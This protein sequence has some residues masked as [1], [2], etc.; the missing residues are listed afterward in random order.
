MKRSFFIQANSKQLLGAKLA[1][2]AIETTGGASKAG[3]P[4]VIL[5]VDQDKTYLS[6][7]GKTYRRGTE[8]RTHDK[9]DLQFF[10]LSRF[11]PPEIMAYEGRSVVI[12]P[13]IFALKEVTSLFDTELNGNS[14]AACKKSDGWDSSVMVLENRALSHWKINDILFSLTSGSSDYNDWSRLKKES[15]VEI[16]REWNSLDLITENTKFLHTTNRLTQPWRTG[17][18]IDFTF[19][20]PPRLF[21]VIPRF[22]VVRPTHYLPHPDQKVVQAFKTLAAQALD[23]GAVTENDIHTAIK[24]RDVRPDFFDFLQTST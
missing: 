16:S 15:V 3:I 17:L 21:G 12:D 20:K 14:I 18:P 24:S 6:Y 11:M 22:W 10:T 4:V 2:F 5:N 7:V 8:V 13:D 19:N 1:K 23:A 9:N